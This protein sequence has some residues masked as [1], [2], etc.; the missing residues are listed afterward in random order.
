[1]SDIPITNWCK[2][3]IDKYAS[4]V[5]NAFII[6]GNIG[7]Y[8][9]QTVKIPDYLEI[10]LKDKL[11]MTSVGTYDPISDPSDSIGNFNKM[12]QEIMRHDQRTAYIISYPN[13][14]M[15]NSPNGNMGEK[16][17]RMLVT[18]HKALTSQ[19][20]MSSEN[21]V[22]LLCESTKD[23]HPM[24]ISS[25]IKTSLI[26][27]T[28]PDDDTRR[29]F[30]AE[31]KKNLEIPTDEDNV[32]DNELVNLTAGLTL[33]NIEDILL[34]ADNTGVLTR[35]MILDRKK[36]LIKKE[37]GEIIELLDT[38]GATLANFAGQDHIK[39]YFKDV[40]IDAIRENN[41]KIV[42]KGIMLM[43]PPGTGKTY[44]STCLA[45][46]AGINFVEFKMSKIQN[47]WVG[48]SE[49]NL[50][51][52]FSVFRAL[53]PVGVFIDE[54]DQ[55]LSRGD[56][57]SHSVNKNMFGMFLHE[58][59]KP[60]NRGKI[61]WIGATNYP[62]K[63]DEALKRSGRFDKKIPFF[64]PS[65]DERKTVFQ[66]HLKKTKYPLDT[67][68]DLNDLA[69]KTDGYTQAE[70][71][72]VVVKALEL[73]MRKHSDT[74]KKEHLDLAIEYMLSAQNNKITEMEDIAL[75]ECN[76]LEF[77]PQKYRERRRILMQENK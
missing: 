5:D 66:I 30:I 15:P 50:E 68:I 45:G 69:Q 27:V 31:I 65:E 67:D 77:L 12:C 33:I 46:D 34:N 21:L 16:A 14:L 74:L 52:A 70:I 8:A 54:M 49:K 37:H 23:I 28:L 75:R 76:D 13:I 72:N 47:K 51:K 42:P 56:G 61:L 55:T 19:A 43:G 17:S 38:Q 2:E 6:A 22:I 59:S 25:N 53:A 48:E 29:Q 57:D 41:L 40:V 63:I 64:A 3:M 36:E 35:D 39:A 7:D 26:E 20:F 11:H 24:L 58:L 10:I 73:A 9:V 1:M 44:F 32:S 4:G 60:E 62:D 18:L 71:E